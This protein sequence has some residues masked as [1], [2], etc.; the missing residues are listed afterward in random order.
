MKNG[1]YVQEYEDVFDRKVWKKLQ[2]N[3]LKVIEDCSDVTDEQ[4]PNPTAVAD[5]SDGNNNFCLLPSIEGEHPDL[6]EVLNFIL[7]DWPL[8]LRDMI[9]T[10]RNRDLLMSYAIDGEQALVRALNAVGDINRF[11]FMLRTYWIRRAQLYFDENNT[12]LPYVPHRYTLENPCPHSLA[13]FEMELINR[14]NSRSGHVVENSPMLHNPRLSIFYPS[15]Q[16]LFRMVPTV[17]VIFTRCTS[18][19]V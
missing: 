11:R 1:D 10:R 8:P 6:T 19:L 12:A 17:E 7:V 9:H 3:I 5:P 16:F 13:E 14:R 2:L 4:T 15:I 18:V